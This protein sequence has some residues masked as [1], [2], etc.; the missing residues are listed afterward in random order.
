M[1]NKKCLVCGDVFFKLPSHSKKYWSTRKYCGYKCSLT[2]TSLGKGNPQYSVPKGNIPWNK[3]VIYNKKMKSR[4]NIEGLKKGWGM[5]K[6]KK[7]PSMSGENHHNW[8]TKIEMNCLQCGKSMLLPPWEIKEGRKL[9]SRECWALY[10][11]GINNPVFKGDKA[12]SI[13]RQ[14][15]MQLPEYQSWR[16]EILKRDDFTCKICNYRK[17]GK[18]RIPLEVD[19][20]KR[21][22]FIVKEN[23]LTTV[24]DARKCDELWN[25]KNGQTVCKPCHRT[26]DTYGTTGLTKSYYQTF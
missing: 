2:I 22:Y 15:V 19:H 8:K 7:F 13:F 6:G 12:V 23:N 26:L 11:R 9:C 14:R 16:M 4:M 21:F 17:V 24:E 10:T 18:K 1:D 20:I 3:G 25:T 5:N